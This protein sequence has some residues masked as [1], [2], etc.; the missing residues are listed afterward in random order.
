MVFHVV[1]VHVT[2]PSFDQSCPADI[3]QPIG[4]RCA[5]HVY[6]CTNASLCVRA[7]DRRSETAKATAYAFVRV[8]I[9]VRVRRVCACV[10]VER[11]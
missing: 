10:C 7:R 6:D 9:G 11:A 2:P 5:M 4:N 8:R 3:D 1:N